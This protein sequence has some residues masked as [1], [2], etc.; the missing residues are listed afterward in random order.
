MV[1]FILVKNIIHR[2]VNEIQYL[3]YIYIFSSRCMHYKI[4]IS[5]DKYAYF[6]FFLLDSVN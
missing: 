5:F 4:S 3:I 1:I 2:T 6:R